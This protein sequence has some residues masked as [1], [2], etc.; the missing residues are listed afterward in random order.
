MGCGQI[1]GVTGGQ[2]VN[3]EGDPDHPINRGSLCSKGSALSQL[4]MVDGEV[5]PRRLQKVRYH[6]PGSDRWEEK[7]WDWAV[8]E[9]ALPWHW[10]YVGLSRGDSANVLTARIADSNTMLPEY[11]AF[12][13]Q[14]RAKAGE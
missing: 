13:C 7:S 10:G 8:E 4:A 2:V 9:I 3:I 6:A 12:L 5:N 1:V 14:V 11:R